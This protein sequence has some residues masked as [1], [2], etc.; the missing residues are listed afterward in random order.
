MLGFVNHG[1]S[2]SRRPHTGLS[3]Q[4]IYFLPRD[5]A[6]PRR[7]PA[8]PAAIQSDIREA[9]PERPPAPH[10]PPVT[11]TRSTD[12]RTRRLGLSGKALLCQP[13]P[14]TAAHIDGQ[15]TV[16]RSCGAS[17]GLRTSLP[18]GTSCGAK[19]IRTPDLLLCHASGLQPPHI[20]PP[21]TP[22]QVRFGRVSPPAPPRLYAIPRPQVG[23]HAP[24]RPLGCRRGHAGLRQT[25]Q[26]VGVPF[27]DS[28]AR[29]RPA[30]VANVANVTAAAPLPRVR[31]LGKEI[32]QVLAAGS[33]NRRRC[34][35]RAGV[36]RGRRW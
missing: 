1:A 30:N 36:L 14:T 9:P 8:A 25:P 26:A 12:P 32:E 16:K 19:E 21:L 11:E 28:P 29:L 22:H 33:R 4:R 23:R 7:W 13:L 18:P 24:A 20:G 27:S 2:G 6:R 34:H 31:D 3:R 15:M 10:R 5:Q 35:R 17:R